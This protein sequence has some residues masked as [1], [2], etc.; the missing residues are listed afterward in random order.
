MMLIIK[1]LKPLGKEEVAGIIKVAERQP[2]QRQA[3][4]ILD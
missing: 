1:R 4:K 2:A 3:A